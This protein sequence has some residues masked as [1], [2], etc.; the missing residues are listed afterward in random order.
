MGSP[1]E[2][3]SSIPERRG[4][5]PWPGYEYV[6]GWGIFGLPFDSGHVLALR[7]FPEGSFPAYRALWHRTP[8]GRWSIHVDGPRVDLACPRYFGPACDEV[9]TARI[10]VG[11]TGARTLQVQVDGPHLEWTTRLARSPLMAALNPISS[12]LPTASWRS[13]VMLRTRE[14]LA[15]SLGLGQ[16]AFAGE[17]PSGHEGVLMPQR[18]YL[19]RSARATL[20]GVDLGQ[21]TRARPNPD[22]GGVPLPA[23]GVLA[24][25]QAA[26]GIKDPA[27]F[28]RTLGEVARALPEHGS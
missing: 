24:I 19:V 11:W 6:R 4:D 18:M 1:A 12:A 9:G 27:E 23:R 14:V 28:R 21:P 26:W 3:T 22:I 5:A 2:L 20:D 15:R 25:G 16:I 8:E 13:S 10:E 7:V 17:M